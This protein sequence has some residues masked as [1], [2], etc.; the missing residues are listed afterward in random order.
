MIANQR[1]RKTPRQKNAKN[2]TKTKARM[3]KNKKG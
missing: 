2:P 3:Q 1:V